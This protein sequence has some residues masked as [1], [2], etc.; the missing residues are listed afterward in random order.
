M[1]DLRIKMIADADRYDRFACRRRDLRE[2]PSSSRAVN[3]VTRGEILG[4]WCITFHKAFALG[5]GAVASFAARA[6]SNQAAG[7]INTGR[8]ELHKFHVLQWQSGT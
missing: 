3:N 6:F 5:I 8:M 4:A 2:F 7:A 1:Q